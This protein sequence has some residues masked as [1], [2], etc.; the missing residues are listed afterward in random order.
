MTIVYCL[1]AE[2]LIEV[3]SPELV[4]LN[5]GHGADSST[6][7]WKVTGRFAGDAA[8]VLAP[9]NYAVVTKSDLLSGVEFKELKASTF[10]QQALVDYLVLLKASDFAGI[11]HSSFAWSIALKR[12]ERARRSRGCLE[13]PGM[14]SGG[15]SKIM[16]R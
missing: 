14:L 16:G 5:Q 15:L 11:A 9:N 8:R 4:F 3:A 6:S 1:K 13:A 10:G 7:G 12:H 2:S